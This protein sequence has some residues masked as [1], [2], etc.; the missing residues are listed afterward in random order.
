LDTGRAALPLFVVTT[1]F[2]EF[3]H[4]AAI[5]TTQKIAVDFRSTPPRLLAVLECSW[6]DARQNCSG[7]YG[8]M[9]TTFRTGN[10]ID[11]AWAS[12]ASTLRC[13]DTAY[14][15]TAWGGR[16][17]VTDSLL[18]R[19]RPIPRAIAI[20]AALARVAQAARRFSIA[21]GP[22]PVVEGVGRLSRVASI[23]SRR[24]GTTLEVFAARGSRLRFDPRFFLVERSGEKSAATE[25]VLHDPDPIGPDPDHELRSAETLGTPSRVGP[26]LAI[27]KTQES[28]SG[29]H[30]FQILA[31]EG[32]GRA[33]Y[34]LGV[35]DGDT[36]IAHVARLATHVAYPFCG[37]EAHPASAV[38]IAVSDG[39]DPP[40]ARLDMEP[41]YFEIGEGELTRDVEDKHVARRCPWT[42]E[43]RWRAGRGFE[44]IDSDATC[45]AETPPRHIAI[46]PAGRIQVVEI[47]RP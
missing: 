12:A 26:K 21:S 40:T 46:D 22:A 3:G 29:L 5:D 37:G 43:V 24:A 47:E 19:P 20:D 34:W 27:L 36:P 42:A 31:R 33:V 35:E 23:A 28:P 39:S 15:G 4:T 13:G 25:L 30:L 10:S 18:G 14:A 44:W 32:E 2:S 9:D 16:F 7:G 6:S 11:C 38:S 1:S 8:F 17:W 45:A 41:G